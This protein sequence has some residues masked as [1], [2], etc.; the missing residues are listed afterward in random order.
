ME[1]GLEGI[2]HWVGVV[3]K[4]EEG[5]GAVQSLWGLGE[6]ALGHQG[7]EV[8]LHMGNLKSAPSIQPFQ[9]AVQLELSVVDRLHTEQGH[10]FLHTE[11]LGSS[12]CSHTGTLHTAAGSVGTTDSKVLIAGL[13]N[14][15][16][17]LLDTVQ[18]VCGCV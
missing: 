8:V 1:K 17:Q 10:M 11:V 13:R 14:C 12:S 4:G 18:P 2:E 3:W 9:C 15:H 16:S 7:L 6:E 5:E